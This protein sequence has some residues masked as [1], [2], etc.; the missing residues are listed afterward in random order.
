VIRWLGASRDELG[1]LRQSH[2]ELRDAIVAAGKE[3]R[4]LAA[5]SLILN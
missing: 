2:A 3:L 5:K 1:G 4:D